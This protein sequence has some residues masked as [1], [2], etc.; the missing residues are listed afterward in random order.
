MSKMATIRKTEGAT[1]AIM[2][3]LP[4]LAEL[5]ASTSLAIKMKR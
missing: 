4:S 1:I 3:V 2:M 5:P